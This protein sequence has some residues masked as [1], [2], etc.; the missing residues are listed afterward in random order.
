[1]SRTTTGPRCQLGNLAL[2]SI[3]FL[4][5]ARQAADILPDGT[6]RRLVECLTVT[7][8]VKSP[9]WAEDSAASPPRW[10]SRLAVRCTLFSAKQKIGSTAARLRSKT[11]SVL[12]SGPIRP[13]SRA[14]APESP[15]LRGRLGHAQ[16]RSRRSRSGCGSLEASLSQ[17]PAD[18]HRAKG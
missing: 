2:T 14:T 18:R 12:F 10:R 3:A 1:M 5:A 17:G 4:C 8:A 11:A 7:M 9:S 15:S 6:R 16:D 13:R